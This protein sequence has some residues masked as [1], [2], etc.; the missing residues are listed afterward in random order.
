M[1][2]AAPHRLDLRLITWNIHGCIDQRGRYAPERTARVIRWLRPDV[3]ALQEANLAADPAHD[4]LLLALRGDLPHWRFA[5]AHERDCRHRPGEITGFG[6]LLLSRWPL[7]EEAPL[8]LSHGAREPRLA[9]RTRL[10]TPAGGL[11]CWVIHFGL[12]LAERRAQGRRV[13]AALAKMP[14][15]EPLILTGDFNEWLPRARSLRELHRQLV[16]LPARRSFPATRPLL[17]LDQVWIRGPLHPHRMDALRD[18][19][20]HRISDHLPVVADLTLTP[21]GP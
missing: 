14:P 21:D 17:A 16:R 9:L 19:V 4:R 6:N 18:P 3:V 8:E 2:P 5:P 7:I 13:A 20:L 1:R 10:A 11:H 15:G 12:G